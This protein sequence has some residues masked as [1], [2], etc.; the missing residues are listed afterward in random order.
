MKRHPYLRGIDNLSHGLIVRVVKEK[1][2]IDEALRVRIHM[3]CV[4][5]STSDT[6]VAY[7]HMGAA[8]GQKALYCCSSG[9]MGLYCSTCNC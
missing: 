2:T 9:S 3:D 6:D 8:A 4:L 1:S 5:L 7:A